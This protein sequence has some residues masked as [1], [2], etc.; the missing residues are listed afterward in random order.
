FKRKTIRISV[1]WLFLIVNLI[2]LGSFINCSNTQKS[3]DVLNAWELRIDGKV[4]DAKLL[5]DSILEKDPLNAMAYY[6][7]SRTLDYMD[8]SEEA[9]K[10]IQKAFELEPDNVIYA[11]SNANN[12]FLQAYMKMQMEQEGVK[13]AVEKTC[14]AY[15]KV[16]EI[17]P[18]Y[19]E[20][21]M[22][23]V[24]IYGY[25]PE[26][27]GGNKEK[28]NEFISKMEKLD[29]FYGAKAKT[30]NL[31]EETNFVDYWNNYMAEE[32]EC[33]KSLKELGA[34]YIFADDIENAE[35]CYEKAIS[36]DPAQNVRLLDLARYHMMKVM[37]NRELAQ[38]ELPNA[39][40]YLNAFLESQ[41]EPIAPLK[42]W[43]YANL[44]RFEMFLGNNEKGEELM[45]LAESTDPYFS[46]A[47]GVP[48]P[49]EFV[50]PNEVV[51]HFGS[52]FSPF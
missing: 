39:I 20:A 30:A 9:Q 42:A 46:R 41:P 37:Q 15:L 2:F 49:G 50:A 33:V 26:D 23:L 7:L 17:E 1:L 27:M 8:K 36:L 28:A 32:G 22:Y 10:A 3:R 18:D 6:E 4:D 52:F 38:E 25:L 34:T 29:P 14:E 21:M 43:S 12:C 48:G 5:L 51:H 44:S 47:F 45:K 24:E 11:Y 31:P 19:P 40:K 16:L 35:K 13:E